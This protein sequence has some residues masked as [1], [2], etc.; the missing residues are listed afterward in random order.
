MKRLRILYVCQY[1]PPEIGAPAARASELAREWVKDGHLVTVLTGF[2]N[3][4]N[5]IVPKEYKWKLW[6]LTIREDYYGVD[7]VRTWLAPFA[8]RRSWERILNYASFC[9]SASIRC[10][11]LRKYDVVI[12]TS[13]QLLQGIVGLVLKYLKRTPFVFEVRDLWPE[14]LQAVGAF[15]SNSTLVKCLRALANMLYR[16]SDKI[17]VVTPRFRSHLIELSAVP[18]EKIHV[19]VNGV[20]AEFLAKGEDFDARKAYGLEGYFVVSFVGTIGNAHGLDTLVNTARLMSNYAKVKFLVVGDGA[21]REKLVQDIANLGLTNIQIQG[22]QPR[23]K[24]PAILRASDVCLVMLKRSPVFETVIPTKMLEF[25]AAARPVILA[26]EGQAAEIVR[27]A[28]SGICIPPEN[29]EALMKAIEYMLEHSVEA[30]CFGDQGREYVNR[31]F[32]RKQTAQLYLDILQ[33]VSSHP[34]SARQA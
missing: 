30:S 21:E 29:P 3:H 20:D 33:E 6:L 10:V 27:E 34:G 16:Q 24:I 17:V 1:F 4:P 13:P 23:A 19:I 12:A 5:G 22:P 7:V 26:V 9:V 14:S 11:F 25:M 32:S 8:N 15:S 2:P 31:K 28:R 18:G